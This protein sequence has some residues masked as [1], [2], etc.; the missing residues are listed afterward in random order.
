MQ[1]MHAKAGNSSCYTSAPILLPCAQDGE[2]QVVGA[3]VKDMLTQKE[4]E[5]YARVVINAT[6]PFVDSIR[7]LSNK[8]RLS[9]PPC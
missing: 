1:P 2:D 5:V 6:G 8:A 4:Q 9:L 7:Q 3:V